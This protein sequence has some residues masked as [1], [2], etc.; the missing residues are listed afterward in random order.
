MVTTHPQIPQ[1]NR[2]M[3]TDHGQLYTIDVSSTLLPNRGG[4]KFNTFHNIQNPRNWS[5]V[6]F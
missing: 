1:L 3:F 4:Q 6:C 5:Y 2:Q